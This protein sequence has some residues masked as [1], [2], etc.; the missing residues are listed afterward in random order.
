MEG[1]M[2]G[3]MNGRMDGWMDEWMDGWIGRQMDDWTYIRM[4]NLRSKSEITQDEVSRCTQFVL[5]RLSQGTELLF[6]FV[7]VFS[8]ER[9]SDT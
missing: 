3:W 2:G 4:S 1:L 5:L 6:T 7:R 8:T 9:P